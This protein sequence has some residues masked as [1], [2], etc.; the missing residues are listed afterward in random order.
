MNYIHGRLTRYVLSA[1]LLGLVISGC[2]ARGP[3]PHGTATL[4]Y[5]PHEPRT[6][7]YWWSCRF[8]IFWPPGEDLNLTADLLLA[9]AVVQPILRSYQNKMIYWRFHRRAARDDTGHQFSFMFYADPVTAE[10]VFR[11][12]EHNETLKEATAAK[13]VEKI[14]V[15]D[16][17]KPTRPGVADTSD[18]HWSPTLQR[19]WPSFIMGVSSLWLGL[20]DEAVA[21]VP[22]EGH[23]VRALLERY[24]K[25]DASVTAIWY[26]EGQHAFLHHLNAVFGY[27]PLLIRKE[28]E[29]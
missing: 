29:F 15:D 10:E 7:T 27:T 13:I 12:I 23:D 2:A 21:K 22:E 24:R 6:H 17:S 14:A 20:I 8:K 26:K 19:T 1:C 4:G 25:A 9:H 18:P 11:E 28:M 16:V 3:E 5:L